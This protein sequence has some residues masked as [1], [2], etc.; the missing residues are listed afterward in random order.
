MFLAG[1]SA[2]RTAG[3]Q[4]TARQRGDF[5]HCDGLFR[6]TRNALLRDRSPDDYRHIDWLNGVKVRHRADG[7][8]ATSARAAWPGSCTLRT[9]RT[10]GTTELDEECP[11]FVWVFAG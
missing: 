11:T 7:H 10:S 5:W 9:S 8:S 6:A 2:I 3:V 1:Y 4:R